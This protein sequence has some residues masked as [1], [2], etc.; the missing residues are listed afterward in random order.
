MCG[1]AAGHNIPS[2][3]PDP[4]SP[5]E[6]W[7]VIEAS[8]ANIDQLLAE[9]LLR[10]VTF[11]IA[12]S[13]GSLKYLGSHSDESRVQSLTRQMLAD[14]S[15]LIGE[16]RDP[17]SSPDSVRSDWQKYRKELGELEKFYQPELLRTEVFICPM[18]PLDR[19]LK[20]DEK[21]SVCGMPLIR[22]HLPA[23][24][25]YEKPGE[26]TMKLNVVCSPLVVGRRAEMK[27]HLST[28]NGKPVLLDDLLEMHTKKIHLLI[29]DRSLGDYHH[30]H[31][32]P[33]GV[34]GEYAFS[35]TPEKPGPYRVWADV[36]PAA[37]SIQEYVVADI[38]AV[39]EPA[40]LKDRMTVS[41]AIVHGRTYVL[42]L[43][44]GG[45]PIHAGQT[46]IGTIA[47]ADADGKPFVALEPVMGAFAHIVGF[48]EDLKTVLHIHP[49]SKEPAN[50]ADR[51]GP[52]FAFKFYAPVA[53]FYRLYGQVQIDGVSQ[54][55]PF[56]VTVL[57]AEKLATQP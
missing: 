2:Q 4:Q 45:K 44:T 57:P 34:P 37:T 26:P 31:P 18:H 40:A 3:L 35:F 19:H 56:G 5:G 41:T 11:Q 42:K 10:D 8:A 6:A 51:A 17:K 30:E 55:P 20:A 12:N 21:C 24:A 36:V 50:P 29:N 38:P 39:T 7:N 14:G 43:N 13:D 53:G 9:N 16:I 49:Y 48:N 28:A 54:F 15:D 22:R 46:V 23:S 32:V 27:I 52:V 1:V 33:T 25:V 47:V